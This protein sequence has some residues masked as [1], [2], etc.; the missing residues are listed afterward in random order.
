MTG[1]SSEAVASILQTPSRRRPAAAKDPYA[2]GGAY[3]KDTSAPAPPTAEFEFGG[4]IGTSL[5]IIV[6]HV[7]LYYVYYVLH[8]HGGNL[9]LPS[10][11]TSGDASNPGLTEAIAKAWDDVQPTYEAAA[12]YF[13]FIGLQALFAYIMPGLTLQGRVDANG[14]TLTYYCN[15]YLAWWAS[16][17][18][19]AALHVTGTLNIKYI[20]THAG[21]F[22][23]VAVIFSNALALYLHAH[24]VLTSTAHRMTGNVVYDFF[25]G[26]VLHPRVGILDIKMFAEIRIS[27]FLLFL[28]TASAAAAQVEQ[29]GGLTPSMFVMLVA[30]FLYANAC[31]KGEH[32]V[33]PTWDITYEKFGWMLCFWNFAGVPF[34][35]CAQSV[36]IWKHSG[37]V[38]A[39]I[40]PAMA[41][42]LL[43]VLCGAYY[44]WD[45]SQSQ[46]NHFRL[47]TSGVA[48]TRWTFPYLPW[49]I[50]RNPKH[51]VTARGT[52]LLTDGWWQYARKIHYTMDIIMGL[53]WGLSCGFTHFIPYLY[54]F[55]FTVMITHRYYRDIERCARNYGEDWKKYCATV[56]YAFIPGVV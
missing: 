33:P 49:Q 45:T 41:T 40:S 15:A 6:S 47:E 23:T 24:A 56:P 19:L 7:L 50:L 27:W 54:V 29:H 53:V 39:Q 14:H 28:L 8:H 25:M 48:I 26:A 20:I 46:K 43:L 17:A 31:A 2:P 52:P 3:A 35:Y 1:T 11:I 44:I 9:W 42:A 21:A 38:A 13:G 30:H 5:I 10:Q 12:W 51:I 18:L 22:M 55:F 36:F 32:Y 34:L 16:L 4:P 37:E